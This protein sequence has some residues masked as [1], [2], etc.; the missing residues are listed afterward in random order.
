[1]QGN[2]WP[3]RV[4]ICFAFGQRV[5][6][7]ARKDVQ[8]SMMERPSRKPL[9]GGSSPVTT[10]RASAMRRVTRLRFRPLAAARLEFWHNPLG[11]AGIKP[12]PRHKF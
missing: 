11:L 12:G 4:G 9:Q 8:R 5:D 6:A 10:R 1:M 3:P 7:A 2:N